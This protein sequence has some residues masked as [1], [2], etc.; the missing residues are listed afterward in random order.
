MRL[1]SILFTLSLVTS[2]NLAQSAEEQ[3]ILSYLTPEE[4]REAGEKYYLTET[5]SLTGLVELETGYAWTKTFDQA[6]SDRV[7]EQLFVLQTALDWSPTPWASLEIVYEYDSQ[8]RRHL[9]DEFLATIEPKEDISLEFGRL[10]VPFGEY[11]SHFISGPAIELGE[12]RGYGIVTSIQATESLELSGFL[13]EGRAGEFG[14]DPLIDLD[15]GLAM[16]LQLSA[17][18][19]LGASYVS[20]LGDTEEDLLADT[21]FEFT[22]R[23]PAISSF[24]RLVQGRFDVTFEYLTALRSFRELE[25]QVNRP[26]GWN[27]EIGYQLSDV[28]ETAFRLEYNQEIVDAPQFGTGVACSW[29]ITDHLTLAAEYLHGE[30]QRGISR[31]FRENDIRSSE[32]IRAQLIFTGF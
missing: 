24:V 11:F 21:N 26:S 15:W 4:R 5:L 3:S 13:Y 12:I 20:D 10:F 1:L 2:T 8:E 32:E 28:L 14:A 16:E 29:R 9:I 6:P 27:L 23:T 19:T 18:I 17:S 7:Y 25:S 31:D 22:R 30:Y